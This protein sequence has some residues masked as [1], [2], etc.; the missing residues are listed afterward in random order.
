MKELE[1]I[2]QSENDQTQIKGVE[3]DNKLK[4]FFVVDK[5]AKQ[6]TAVMALNR[7]SFYDPKDC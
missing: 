3:L 2:I 4:V 5:L 1:K 7:G 6:S